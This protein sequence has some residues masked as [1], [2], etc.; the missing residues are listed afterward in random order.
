MNAFASVICV[1]SLS[2]WASG[3]RSAIGVCVPLSAVG[4]FFTR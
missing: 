1:V 2:A 3:R 4:A